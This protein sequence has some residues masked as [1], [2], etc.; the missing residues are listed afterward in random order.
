MGAGCVATHKY[1]AKTI[2]PV[3]SRVTATEQ[4]NTDQDKTLADHSKDLDS[5]STDLS[6]TK[7]GDLGWV[8]PGVHY[9]PWDDVVFKLKPGEIS[10]PFRSVH[11]YHIVLVE[12][13]RTAGW[14]RLEDKRELL[15]EL[16][17]AMRS[18]TEYN[19]RIEEAR[20]RATIWIADRIDLDSPVASP[21]TSR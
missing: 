2:S 4:K 16:I 14:G 5:L 6:R 12:E 11:G 20:K 21:S 19:R 8:T 17:R 18:N 15:D 13:H 7:G 1:V 3:E 9:A 10:Q